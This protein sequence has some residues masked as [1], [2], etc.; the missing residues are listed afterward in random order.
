MPPLP[1]IITA[2]I[3]ILTVVAE[4]LSQKNSPSAYIG[5]SLV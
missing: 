4:S 5:T 2:A 1:Q 3:V